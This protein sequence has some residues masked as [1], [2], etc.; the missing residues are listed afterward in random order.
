MGYYSYQ[1]LDEAIIGVLSILS[2]ESKL[3]VLFNFSQFLADAIHGKFINFI[4]EE[5]FQDSSV[6]VY[7]FLYFQADIFQ[8]TMTKLNE[9][10]EP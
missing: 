6:L 3:S 2:T 7:M 4:I 5:V 10:G 1:C 8:F 9:E